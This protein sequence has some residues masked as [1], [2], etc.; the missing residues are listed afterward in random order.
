MAL[1]ELATNAGKYGALSGDAGRAEITWGIEH[2]EPGDTFLMSWRERDGPIVKA[3]ARNGFGSTVI[4]QMA[5]MSL[6]A[7]VSLDY[8]P[9]GLVWRLQCPIGGILESE[10]LK[11]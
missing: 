7:V 9:S 4:V 10:K 5:E 1:H 6:N 2:E 8:E 3:P 11:V